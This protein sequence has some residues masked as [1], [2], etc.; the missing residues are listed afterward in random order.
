MQEFLGQAHRSHRQAEHAADLAIDGEGQLA[1]AAAQVDEQQPRDPDA[2]AGDHSKVDEPALFQA[3]DHLHPPAGDRAHPIDEGARVAGIAQRAGGDHAHE[4]H[5]V[6]LAGAVKPAQHLDGVLHGVGI[7]RSG[8]EDRFAQPRDLAVFVDH[9][10][11]LAH[12]ACDL[13]ADRVGADV[14]RGECRHE[15]KLGM[16]SQK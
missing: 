5:A 14:N 2:G 10:Q 8:A 7:E 9:L 11:A 4:V 1:T 3:G 12:Q 6:A 15:I 16:L 13:Q